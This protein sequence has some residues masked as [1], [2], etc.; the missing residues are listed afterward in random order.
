[1]LVFAGTR[2]SL[3]NLDP[4]TKVLAKLNAPWELE[5]IEGGNQSFNIPKSSY[6]TQL[7]V[8]GQI[9]RKRLNGW[10]LEKSLILYIKEA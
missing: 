5:I 2:D 9:L 6:L 7:E 4:L 10:N 8:Y 1:M 3:C